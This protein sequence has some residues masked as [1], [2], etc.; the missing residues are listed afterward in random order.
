MVKSI[1]N[2]HIF[3]PYVLKM[4]Y[5]CPVFQIVSRTFYYI[6]P[7]I[8]SEIVVP[9][10]DLSLASAAK[11]VLE[12]W[13]S[14]S[15]HQFAVQHSKSCG[16]A[17]KEWGLLKLSGLAVTLK[18]VIHYS[19]RVKMRDEQKQYMWVGKNPWTDII[20]VTQT[21]NPRNMFLCLGNSNGKVWRILL[22]AP[23]TFSEREEAPSLAAVETSKAN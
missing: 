16:R 4:S 21:D 22:Q 5:L 15:S 12:V 7:R 3:R 20:F 1:I 23:N 2:V 17:W 6:Y 13:A 18:R 14:L 9:V 11:P 8:I 19:V 10:T